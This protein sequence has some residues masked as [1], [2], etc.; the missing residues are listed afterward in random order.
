[1]VCPH[2]LKEI[3]E[4][5]INYSDCEQLTCPNCNFIIYQNI[6][7]LS[8]IKIEKLFNKFDYEYDFNNDSNLSIIIAPN[9]AGK[10]TILN[11][12]NF[13]LFPTIQGLKKIQGIPVAKFECIMKNGTV[14]TYEKLSDEY[15][16][17]NIDA[18]I[19]TSFDY[20]KKQE[21][22]HI[23]DRAGHFKESTALFKEFVK[24]GLLSKTLNYV[25]LENFYYCVTVKNEYG[26]KVI[27]FLQILNDLLSNKTSSQ[28]DVTLKTVE[29]EEDIVSQIGRVINTK[30]IT[31]KR[32][33]AKF[34]QDLESRKLIS[35][36][37]DRKIKELDVLPSSYIGKIESIQ[38]IL[39]SVSNLSFMLEAKIELINI[40]TIPGN[41][42]VFNKRWK[43]FEKIFNDRNKITGKTIERRKNEGFVIKQDKKEIPL[44]K[45][46]S[47]EIN[48]FALFY[49]LI[50]NVPESRIFLIDE[51][52]IS[53]H[54]DWQETMIDYF[55]DIIRLNGIQIILA[56]HSPHIINNHYDLLA[57]RTVR[58]HGCK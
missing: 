50:F 57:K 55:L 37:L 6:N 43:L 51:P 23:Q 26:V 15:I 33:F 1:M 5:F 29:A 17:N 52:E 36:L 44:S 54:I 9:G 4:N 30:F 42:T 31:T 7:C 35:T 2:C 19:V 48:D 3:E 34:E 27:N 8:K 20:R 56:T 21:Q 18:Q 53:L 39:D 45:L 58:V 38:K 11:F 46:S 12:I 14:V 28:L 25:E 32:T 49:K 16:S 41:V 22:K 40:S 47:G 13:L 24:E 10:T